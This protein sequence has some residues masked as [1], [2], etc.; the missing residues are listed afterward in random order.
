MKNILEVYNNYLDLT[1][2]DTFDFYMFN[3]YAIVNHSNSI[4][5]STL[6]KE[7]TFLLLDEHLTPANKP[8]NMF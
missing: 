8:L 1:K 3:H 2:G 4:E 6:T 5:G 7:E